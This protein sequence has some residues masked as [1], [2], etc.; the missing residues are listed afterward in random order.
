MKA[1][2]SVPLFVS[3]RTTGTELVC[4]SAAMDPIDP[5][6]TSSLPLAD[7]GTILVVPVAVPVICNKS[8]WEFVPT[9]SPGESH[10][11]FIFTVPSVPM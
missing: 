2:S 10:F 1:S 11:V 8:D 7:T 3:A 5:S 4:K 6:I 9:S